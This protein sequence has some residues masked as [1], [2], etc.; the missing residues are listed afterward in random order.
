MVLPKSYNFYLSRT[1][2]RDCYFIVKAWK[3]NLT[4]TVDVQCFTVKERKET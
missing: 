4:F 2:S 1:L 3:I